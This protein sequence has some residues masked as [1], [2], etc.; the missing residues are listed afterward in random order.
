MEARGA[1][2]A[3]RAAAVDVGLG[4]V[5]DAV[6]AGRRLARAPDA[7]AGRAVVGRDA[8]AAVAA[9]RAR[10][11]AVD[12]GLVAG[13]I[14]VELAVA[15]VRRVAGPGEAVRGEAVTGALQL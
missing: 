14:A 15:A 1:V 7:D 9:R 8:V 12:V 10:A 2:G 6:A 11:A 5:P 4:A 3:G 13:G